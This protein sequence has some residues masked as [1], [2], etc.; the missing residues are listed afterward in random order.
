MRERL[1]RRQRYYDFTLGLEE[2]IPCGVAHKEHLNLLL[3]EAVYHINTTGYAYG[4]WV[5]NIFF[6]FLG[7][8]HSSI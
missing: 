2:I 8:L 3:G 4:P 7:G 1:K 6:F 5:K